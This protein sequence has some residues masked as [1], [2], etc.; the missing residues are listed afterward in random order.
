MR[1]SNI[2]K[3]TNAII[4]INTIIESSYKVLLDSLKITALTW[5]LQ[6]SN[7]ALF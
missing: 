4:L 5:T 3:T 2:F 1:L 6:I 7:A